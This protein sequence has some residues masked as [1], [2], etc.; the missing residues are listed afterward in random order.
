MKYI[1]INAGRLYNDSTK[2]AN[3]GNTGN[4]VRPKVAEDK[5]KSTHLMV[6]T[7]KEELDEIQDAI[8][9]IK[10]KLVV[11]RG[12]CKDVKYPPGKTADIIK[13]AI[14]NYADQL[15]REMEERLRR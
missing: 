5:K 12:L 7:T 8:R 13:T 9:D 14:G 10:N 2:P 6:R 11:L 4:M 15:G 1:D 3:K